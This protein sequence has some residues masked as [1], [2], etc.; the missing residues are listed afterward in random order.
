MAA[1]PSRSKG[2]EPENVD[3]V[4]MP[5]RPKRTGQIDEPVEGNG[6]KIYSFT[7]NELHEGNA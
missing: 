6:I 1:E 3:E 5:I 4:E 7:I 2:K